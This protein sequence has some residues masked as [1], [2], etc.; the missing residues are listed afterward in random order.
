MV[1]W[2]EKL[3]RM[4]EK[5]A[6]EAGREAMARHWGS[7]ERVIGQIKCVMGLSRFRLAGLEGARIEFA[8]TCI[9]VNIKRLARWVAET[10]RRLAE[11][12]GGRGDETAG[13]QVLA[14]AGVGAGYG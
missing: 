12:V 5:V 14:A 2:R 4:R 3:E 8:L 7:V 6:G 10:G 9:A 13:R 1:K 11:A